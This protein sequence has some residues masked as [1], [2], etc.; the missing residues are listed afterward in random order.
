MSLVLTQH[1]ID[2]YMERSGTKKPMRSILKLFSLA[3]SAR[4]LGRGKFYARG[5][6]LVMKGGRVKTV[7]RPTSRIDHQKIYEA[8]HPIL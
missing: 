3:D 2:R 6:V 8:M 5:W 1:A 7:Y 4:P